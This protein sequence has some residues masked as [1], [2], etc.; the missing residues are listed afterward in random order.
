MEMIID[1]LKSELE[2]LEL[3]IKRKESQVYDTTS[4]E[5]YNHLVISA[6]SYKEAIQ[7]LEQYQENKK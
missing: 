7:V 5:H 1:K 3:S 4:K 6:N 2:L